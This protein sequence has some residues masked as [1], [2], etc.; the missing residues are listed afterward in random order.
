MHAPSNK[1]MTSFRP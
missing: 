1:G